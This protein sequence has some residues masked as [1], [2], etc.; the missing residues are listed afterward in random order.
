MIG[1][2]DDR[3]NR[4][5]VKRMIGE[6]DDRW[7]GWSVKRM[8]GETDDRWNGWSVKQMIGETDDRWNRWSV[9][10]MIGETDD[11]WNRW[12]VKRMIGE[13]DDRWNRWSVKQMIG[14]TDD[15]WNRSK[16]GETDEVNKWVWTSYRVNTD[17]SSAI[18]H[19]LSTGIL[20]KRSKTDQFLCLDA[21]LKLVSKDLDAINI[22][23]INCVCYDNYNFSDSVLWA[24]A[25]QD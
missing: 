22:T 24:K 21:P 7:N 8:I 25:D 1:E 4:W 3:W 12:S 20:S 17:I 16:L 6:T 18:T 5:S 2:T 13:T 11:R 14:E 9:K 19:L 15:R 23:V 10:Q